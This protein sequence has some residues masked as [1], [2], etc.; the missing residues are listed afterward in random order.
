MTNIFKLAQ[1]DKATIFKSFPAVEWKQKGTLVWVLL[2]VLPSSIGM[3]QDTEGM[4]AGTDVYE[5][6]FNIDDLAFT[7]GNIPTEDDLIRYANADG[8]EI[9]LQIETIARDKSENS[10]GMWLC[11]CT[12]VA[13]T[14]KAGQI[15]RGQR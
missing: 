2:N 4:T 8:V 15:D 12:K 3:S 7:A 13:A 10:L 5:V 14:N 11:W 1:R 9:T 6:T